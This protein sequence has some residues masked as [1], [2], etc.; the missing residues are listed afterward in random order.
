MAVTVRGK[1]KIDWK[2][3]YTLTFTSTDGLTLDPG[4]TLHPLVATLT[5]T[6]TGAVI[7]DRVIRLTTS[8]TPRVGSGQRRTTDANGQVTFQVSNVSVESVVYTASLIP[9]PAITDPTVTADVTITWGGV[10]C[11][12]CNADISTSP[13]DYIGLDPIYGFGYATTYTVRTTSGDGCATI[14]DVTHAI[15]TFYLYTP[16]D[17]EPDF[18]SYDVNEVAI[19]DG[20]GL[21]QEEIDDLLISLEAERVAA[22]APIEADQC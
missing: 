4:T 12:T 3:N 9:E 19:L 7:T 20:S 17:G 18:S 14:T 11:T 10:V 22:L 21:T 13:P 1:A 2:P 8:P 15:G 5:N 16:P 6:S